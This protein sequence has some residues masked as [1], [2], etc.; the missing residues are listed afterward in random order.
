[1]DNNNEIDVPI[2]YQSTLVMGNN[3]GMIYLHLETVVKTEGYN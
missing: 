3:I 1:M 2:Y